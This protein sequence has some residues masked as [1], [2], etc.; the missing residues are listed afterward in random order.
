VQGASRGLKRVQTGLVQQYALALVLG[1]V[2][3][4][5]VLLFV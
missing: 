4:V 1:V 2:L 3:V 5:A